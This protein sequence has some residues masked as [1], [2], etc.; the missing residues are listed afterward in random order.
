[1]E[2][3]PN[4]NRVKYERGK[5]IPRQCSDEDPFPKKSFSS[6]R[7]LVTG[8]PEKILPLNLR[9]LM[10]RVMTNHQLDSALV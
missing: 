9:A 2:A 10:C 1:M 4:T 7:V 6:M 5:F 3:G 8:V